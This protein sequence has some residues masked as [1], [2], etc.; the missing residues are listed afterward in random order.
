MFGRNDGALIPFTDRSSFTDWMDTMARP[1]VAIVGRPNVGKSSLF[2]RIVGRRHAVVDSEPGVTRDRLLAGAE[3]AGRDFILAD[4]GGLVPGSSDQMERHISDQ[5][6][7]AVAEADAILFVADVQTGVTDLDLAVARELRKVEQRTLLLVNKVDTKEWEA[8]WHEFYGLGLGEPVPVSAMSGRH[9][10]DMLDRVL[11]I[12]P[13]DTP[14]E[15]DEGLRIAVV[16]RPNVGKSSLVNALFGAERVIVDDVPGTTRDAIDTKVT[17]QGV[18]YTLVDTAGLRKHKARYKTGD[19][20]EYFSV[21]RTVNAIER[22]DVA[23][24]LISAVEHIVKQDIEIIDQVMEAGKG[25]VIAANKWDLIPDKTNDTAGAFVSELWRR[26][27]FG[28]HLPVVLISAQN[29]QRIHRVLTDA[30][31]VYEQWQRRVPTHALNDWLGEMN[32][33]KPLPSSKAGLPRVNYVTQVAVGPPTFAFFVN[34][35]RFVGDQAK[36][37]LERSLRETFGFSGAPLRLNFRKKSRDIP[38]T[39]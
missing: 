38:T 31:A 32:R 17:Y 30:S 15:E 35:P 9:V 19:D 10:G 24:V 22:C 29:R 2:N 5:V 12:L 36:R 4:T 7:A 23:V 27:P 21:L 39:G 3:W 11:A 37:Y 1:M 25:I 6:A 16:G 20:I 26:Y 18:K 14:E 28:A 8:D 34:E 13:E 33:E